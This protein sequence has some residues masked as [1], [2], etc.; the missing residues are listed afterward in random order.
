M[1]NNLTVCEE[2]CDFVNYDYSSEKATCS[3]KI[4]TDSTFKISDI[5]I[6]KNKLL[7]SFTDFKNIAN[8]KVLKCNCLIFKKEAFKSNYA[9]IFMIIIIVFFFVVLVLFWSIKFSEL[10][11]ILSAIIYF[12]LNPDSMKKILSKKEKLKKVKRKDNKNKK[13]FKK[14]QNLIKSEY[15]KLKS[16]NPNIDESG[17]IIIGENKT[18]PIKKKA[19]KKIFNK[20]EAK[21][22][23]KNN[24]KTKKCSNDLI[25]RF[26]ETERT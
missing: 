14:G 16:R 25:N 23:I 22:K 12:K 8:I 4:K 1:D 2:D 24:D 10:I 26:V 5:V 21:N 15:K 18:N 6:D 19:N 17:Q 13:K 20:N 11:K 9:N 7:K 3:C